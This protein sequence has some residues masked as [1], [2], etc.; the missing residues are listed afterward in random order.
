MELD[1]DK[2]VGYDKVKKIR[3][4]LEEETGSQCIPVWHTNR[5]LDDFKRMCD[6]YKFVAIGGIR[7]EIGRK[8]YSLLQHFIDEAHKR[9]AKVHGLGFT[10]VR[11]IVANQCMFDTV[12][13]TTWLNGVKFFTLQKFDGKKLVTVKVPKGKTLVASTV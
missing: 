1:I 2:L 6:E 13:S 4:Y 8:R 9:G 12:D 3:K 5:G 7:Q 11:E 10:R